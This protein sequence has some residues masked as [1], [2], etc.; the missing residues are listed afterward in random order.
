M[1]ER[2]PNSTRRQTLSASD[3]VPTAFNPSHPLR[4]M[5]KST[6]PGLATATPGVW[7]A[8]MPIRFS[9]GGSPEAAPTDYAEELEWVPVTYRKNCGIYDVHKK[10]WYCDCDPRRRAVLLR[11]KKEGPTKGL[12]FYRCPIWGNHVET[13]DFFLWKEDA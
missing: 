10:A 9:S 5:V 13:C 7:Q 3:F 8:D 6:P 12:P 11:V 4:T 2:A 1:F